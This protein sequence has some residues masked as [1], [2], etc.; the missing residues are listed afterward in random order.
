MLQKAAARTYSL[1]LSEVRED[2]D[3]ADIHRDALSDWRDRCDISGIKN[4][5]LDELWSET[6][7]FGH[8][9]T[10]AE[11][12]SSLSSSLSGFVPKTAALKTIRRHANW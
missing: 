1:C 3:L 4:W 6:M 2:S 12:S 8:T 10:P 5:R 11:P 7:A 9:I